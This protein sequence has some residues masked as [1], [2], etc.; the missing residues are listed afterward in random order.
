MQKINIFDAWDKL[1]ASKHKVV[2]AVID[3]GV[4]INHPDFKDKI[5]T[6]KNEIPG[7]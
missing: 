5:W 2:I 7:D 6:N 3:E 4:N 1:P